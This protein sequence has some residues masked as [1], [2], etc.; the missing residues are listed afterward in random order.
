MRDVFGFQLNVIVLDMTTDN[1]AMLF[2][3]ESFQLWESQCSGSLLYK[4]HDFLIVNRDG[5]NILS[6]GSVDKKRI[7]DSEGN[8]RIMHSLESCSFL[9]LAKDNKIVF[10][11]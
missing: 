5:I 8:D 3:H 11:N 7:V 1:N 4:N 2:R 6:L 9:K 10:A